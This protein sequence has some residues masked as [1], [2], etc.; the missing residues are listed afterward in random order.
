MSDL[1]Q[2]VE[3]PYELHEEIYLYQDRPV[4]KEHSIW[5]EF[6]GEIILRNVVAPTLIPFIPSDEGLNLNEA[7]LI[8]PGGGLL[9]LALASEGIDVAKKMAER[10]YTAYVL[11]YRLNPTEMLADGFDRQ[12]KT[13]YEEKMSNG[14]GR[15]DAYLDADLAIDDVVQSIRVIKNSESNFQKL[16]YL[17]FSA[18]AK[19]GLD[20]LMHPEYGG[21]FDSLG[22]MYF[23]LERTTKRLESCPPLFASLA[24]DDPLFSKSSFGLLEQWRELEQEVEFHLFKNGGHGFAGKPSG[25]TSDCWL[26]LYINWLNQLET[27]RGK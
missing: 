4:K 8:G 15:A 24:N 12:C 5:T 13:F 3:P 18:G 20:A 10:G 21:E 23:S 14:F 6:N 9:I 26:D 22:L 16:H 17:G 11:K 27:K 19:I 2:N 7:V 1:I 25:A